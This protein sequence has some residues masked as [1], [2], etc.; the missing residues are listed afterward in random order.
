MGSRFGK[1]EEVVRA[2]INLTSDVSS[3]VTWQAL[4]VDGGWQAL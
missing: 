3:Y 1:T 2:S 4:Y